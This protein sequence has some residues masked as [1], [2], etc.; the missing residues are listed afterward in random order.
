MANITLSLHESLIKAGRKYAT[1]H[2]TSLNK[3]I[4]ELLSNYINKEA[5]QNSIDEFLQ[6]AQKKSGNSKGN[7]WSRNDIYD[8]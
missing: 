1:A 3:I 8:V 2:N 4:K 5:Q 7:I 6:L